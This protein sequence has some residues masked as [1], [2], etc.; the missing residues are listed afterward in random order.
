M[1][2]RL[3]AI[4]WI[5][6]G[7]VLGDGC[8]AMSTFDA[9]L[10][11]Q[12]V[13][14]DAEDIRSLVWTTEQPAVR[15]TSVYSSDGLIWVWTKYRDRRFGG[16][17]CVLDIEGRREACHHDE[18]KLERRTLERRT[19]RQ[20]EFGKSITSWFLA[21]SR[22]NQLRP[23]S[24][25]VYPGFLTLLLRDDI[26]EYT[27]EIDAAKHLP[28]KLIQRSVEGTMEFEF[29]SYQTVRGLNLPFKVKRRATSRSWLETWRFEINPDLAALTSR[30]VL[31]YDAGPEAW[32]LRR[33]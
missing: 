18:G 8:D 13:S 25:A 22:W 24:C 32:R 29:L 15:A 31:D 28:R 3:A 2:S 7:P 14:R 19:A 17:V 4:S 27:M 20:V 33:P 30:R 23:V 21:R 11:A 12:G 16:S 9:M 6:V 10:R 1:K 26:G 5:L